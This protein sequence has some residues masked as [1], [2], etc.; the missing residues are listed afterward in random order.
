MKKL[1]IILSCLLSVNLYG[2]VLD[3]LANL[4]ESILHND[5]KKTALATNEDYINFLYDKMGLKEY[6]SKEAFT[7][8]L[9]GM[10][11]INARANNIL[12]VVDFT[13][14]SNNKR[15]CIIDLDSEKLLY[16]TYVAHGRGSGGEIASSFSNKNGSYKSSPGFFLTGE[17]Y[18]GRN[19]NS[20]AL[21]GL[22]IG[23][24]DNT[25]I[26]NIVVHGAD[27]AEEYFIN[28]YGRLG[29]SWGCFAVPRDINDEIIETTKGGT[30]YYA[31]AGDNNRYAKK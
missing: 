31:Y 1:S 13:K 11:G 28:K 5:V 9:H 26:R 12:T 23:V 15:M 7:T 24:N 4:P 29:R 30:V 21:Y 18:K 22:E 8:G 17:N 16:A 19:G 25:R 20:L 3:N 27:Y 6:I 10:V 14:S 2:Y